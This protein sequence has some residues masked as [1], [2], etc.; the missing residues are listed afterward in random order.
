MLSL[1]IDITRPNYPA[2]LAITDASNLIKIVVFGF[3]G[4]P[5]FT[6]TKCAVTRAGNPAAASAPRTAPAA[7]AAQLSPWKSSRNGDELE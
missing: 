7:N 3:F 2:S 1:P 4:S 6:G 5:P